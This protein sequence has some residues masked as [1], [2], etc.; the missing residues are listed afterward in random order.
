MRGCGEDDAEGSV[1]GLGIVESCAE[2]RWLKIVMSN[3]MDIHRSWLALSAMKRACRLREH[4]PSMFILVG[5]HCSRPG[6][7]EQ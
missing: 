7:E 1:R 4:S 2:H 3:K 6:Q 5:R